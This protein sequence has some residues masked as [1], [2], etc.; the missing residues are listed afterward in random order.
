MNFVCA[1]ALLIRHAD[2]SAKP[3]IRRIDISVYIKQ[4]VHDEAK[5]KLI[6][7]KDDFSDV[8]N[9]LVD[10]WIAGRLPI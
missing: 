6:G 4:T 10:G 5:R 1:M 2:L 7:Q 8:V 3:K 9:K